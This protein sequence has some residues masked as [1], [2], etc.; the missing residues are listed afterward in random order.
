MFF[1]LLDSVPHVISSKIRIFAY[2]C[3][4]N[5]AIVAIKIKID[6]KIGI[7]GTNG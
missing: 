3:K 7:T 6:K 4:S 1:I 5:T 2:V